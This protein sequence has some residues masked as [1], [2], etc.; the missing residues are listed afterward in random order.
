[1]ATFYAWSN[2]ESSK[3]TVSVGGVVT[4]DKLGVSKEGFAELV[5]AGAV[6]TQKYPETNQYESPR[7]AN[8]R[9]LNESIEEAR[10]NAY[11]DISFLDTTE[12]E[13]KSSATS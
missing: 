2:I 10:E 1:M 11:A 7:E 13:E 5:E 8:I 4:A 12:E 3:G 6:R 9:K